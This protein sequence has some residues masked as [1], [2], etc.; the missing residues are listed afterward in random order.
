MLSPS[1]A[2]LSLAVYCVFSFLFISKPQQ[3]KFLATAKNPLKLSI[4][5][6]LQHWQATTPQVHPKPTDV[7]MVSQQ[8]WHDLSILPPGQAQHTTNTRSLFPCIL[9]VCTPSVTSY[10]L[11]I[12]SSAESNFCSVFGKQKA[13]WFPTRIPQLGSSRYNTKNSSRSAQCHLSTACF[14]YQERFYCFLIEL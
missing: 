6:M 2:F 10:I 7:C 11:V 4:H 13:C 8:T 3:L 9:P 1:L 5:K 14:G 12:N